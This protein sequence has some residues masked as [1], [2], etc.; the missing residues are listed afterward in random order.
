[1][2]TPEGAFYAFPDV[3]AFFGRTAPSGAVLANAEAVCMYLLRDHQLA[4]VPGEAFGDANCLR[5]S[6]ATG[7]EVLRDAMDRMERGL[8]AIK[9]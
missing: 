1:M 8:A 5:I 2:P 4:L 7:M 6:Y 3:S 9:P